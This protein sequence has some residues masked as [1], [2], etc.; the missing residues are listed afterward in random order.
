SLRLVLDLESKR[1]LPVQSGSNSLYTQGRAVLCPFASGLF[2]SI[3]LVFP[4]GRSKI[5]PSLSSS[6]IDA[7]P[8]DQWLD[9]GWTLDPEWTKY[10]GY[11]TSDIVVLINAMITFFPFFP[12]VTPS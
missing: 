3:S 6:S 11:G 7:P 4:S 1:S 2:H 5:V 10:Q 9:L 8:I 12:R